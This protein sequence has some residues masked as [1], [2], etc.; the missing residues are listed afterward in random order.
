MGSIVEAALYS[1]AGKFIIYF[2]LL[3][4]GLIFAGYLIFIIAGVVH[5]IKKD[6]KDTKAEE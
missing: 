1:L 4:V 3:P 5:E 6:E 2:V